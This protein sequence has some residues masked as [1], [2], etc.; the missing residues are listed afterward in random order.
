MSL[1][2]IIFDYDGVISESI[3]VK[4]DA[5]AKLYSKYNQ[6]IIDKI[7][8]HHN[9]HGGMS[10]FKKIKYYH[11]NFLNQDISKKNIDL[12]AE[13]FSRIVVK[14]VI[15][16]PYVNGVI[17]FIKKNTK[18]YKLFISTG[19]PQNEINKILSIQGLNIF[20]D[21]IYGSPDSKIQHISYIKNK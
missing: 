2:G 15:Q 7:V 3:K 5:F 1:K 6:N 19:T 11:N 14:D 16:S 8:C 18:R 20:F 9:E 17:D 4:S 21:S 13:K 12:L 10:R